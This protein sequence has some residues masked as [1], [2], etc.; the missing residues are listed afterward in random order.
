MGIKAAGKFVHLEAERIESQG[1]SLGYWVL[2]SP[3]GSGLRIDPGMKQ[4]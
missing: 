3:M 2:F 4:C 1:Q